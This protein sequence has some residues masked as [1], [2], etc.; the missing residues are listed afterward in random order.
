MWINQ[1]DKCGEEKKTSGMRNIV[2]LGISYKRTWD[3]QQ[4]HVG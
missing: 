4:M 2:T 3:K 1:I